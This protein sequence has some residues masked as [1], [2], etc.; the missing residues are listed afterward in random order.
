MQRWDFETMSDWQKLEADVLD[1]AARCTQKENTYAD[2]GIN[3]N[4]FA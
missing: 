1:G 3:E 2:E 4:L